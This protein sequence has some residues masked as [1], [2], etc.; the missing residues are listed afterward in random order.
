MADNELR[1]R[2][3]KII[4]VL[5]LVD[6]LEDE[7]GRNRERIIC[8]R[9]WIRRREER[10]VYHQLMR[11][12]ALDDVALKVSGGGVTR[13]NT[14]KIRATMLQVFESLSKTC[15]MLPQ[16]NVVLKIALCT[17]LHEATCNITLKSNV[18]YACL[19]SFCGST[20]CTSI[21][22]SRRVFFFVLEP[23]CSKSS[24]SAH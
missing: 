19:R 11:E 18:L 20:V 17:L 10:G 7:K 14:N 22:Y 13:T 9:S 12:L 5:L 6:D 21:E 24:E 2:R 4:Q 15:N 23:A 16:Q 1:R 3:L 8:T